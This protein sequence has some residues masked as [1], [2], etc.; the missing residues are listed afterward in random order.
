M[1]TETPAANLPIDGPL[2]VIGRHLYW[3]W[4]VYDS[5]LAEGVECIVGTEA[6]AN[7]YRSKH[8]TDNEEYSADHIDFV[9]IFPM[10]FFRGEDNE[11]RPGRRITPEDIAVLGPC[12]YLHGDGGAGEQVDKSATQ[13]AEDIDAEAR[14]RMAD[15]ARGSFR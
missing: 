13:L 15:L 8:F 3:G 2:A 5:D 12:P 4:V 6:E 1:T 10:I 7:D 11:E 14:G 9:Q